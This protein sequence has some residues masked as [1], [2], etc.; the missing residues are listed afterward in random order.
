MKITLHNIGKIGE[1]SIEL[2]G[3]TVIAGENDTG[4]STV[5]KAL[6]SVFNSLYKIT[7]QIDKERRNSIEQIM[8]FFAPA[9]LLNMDENRDGFGTKKLIENSKKN[10]QNPELLQKEIEGFFLKLENFFGEEANGL[11]LI[12]I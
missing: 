12:H 5:G 9:I 11:S 1:A 7:E 4:K 10:L 8:S 3:I 6:Y 2:H